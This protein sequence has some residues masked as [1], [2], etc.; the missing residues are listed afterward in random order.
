MLVYGTCNP[1]GYGDSSYEGLYLTDS[2]IR[3]ITPTMAGVPVKIEHRGV[4]VGR[5]ITAWVHEGRMDV[6]MELQV[7][8]LRMIRANADDINVCS[9]CSG[10]GHAHRGGLW[11]GI[12]GAG[13]VP[14]AL[15][16]VQRDD[17]QEPRRVP[18][19][20]QQKGG[21]AQPGAAGRARGVQDPG[22]HGPL[23]IV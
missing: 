17:E 7:R 2:D 12:C 22:V 21:G 13:P 1:E 8:A 9:R 11:Q 15:A 14:R 19:G 23:P 20:V 18:A 6:L 16:G 4:D 5:V 10:A 3:E